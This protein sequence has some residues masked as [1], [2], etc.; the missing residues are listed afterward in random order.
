MGKI[1]V[2]KAHALSQLQFIASSVNTPQWAIDEI[3]TIV[4]NFVWDGRPR[5]KPGKASKAWKEGGITLPQ[6][7]DLCRAARIKTV[8]RARDLE[9]A[10]LWASNFMY[11]LRKIGGDS[12]LHPQT[13]LGELTKRS[14]PSYVREHID[15]WQK[16]QK[17]MNSKWANPSNGSCVTIPI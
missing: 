1:T 4:K 12:A 11:E 6:I 8:L 16:L 2:V 9:D 17:A 13:D 14:V 7:E 10:M 3:T 15:A 5:M